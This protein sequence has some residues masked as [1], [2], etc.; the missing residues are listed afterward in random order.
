MPKRDKFGIHKI[1]EER[2]ILILSNSIDS[3]LSSKNSKIELLGKLRRDIETLKHLIRLEYE[4][5]IIKEKTYLSLAHILQDISMMAT[6]WHKS[7]QT[8]NPRK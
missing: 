7:V 2:C 6:G 1:V 3:A 8:Q 5:N 4:L